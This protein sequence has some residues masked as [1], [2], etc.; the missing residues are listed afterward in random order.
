MMSRCTICCSAESENLGRVHL[1]PP[2][3]PTVYVSV[4]F[5]RQAI[6]HTAPLPVTLWGVKVTGWGCRRCLEG[7]AM[8]F[9][10]VTTALGMSLMKLMSGPVNSVQEVFAKMSQFITICHENVTQLIRK[11]LN[12][13]MVIKI[14]RQGHGSQPGNVHTTHTHAIGIG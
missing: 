12:R 2:Q 3:A 10:S 7:R 13:V 14:I 11:I 6:W 8:P 9:W 1:H 5:P 4:A